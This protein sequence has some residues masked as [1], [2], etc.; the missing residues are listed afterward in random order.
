MRKIF[1]CSLVSLLFFCTACD[2][3]LDVTGDWKETGVVYGLINSSSPRQI[4]RINKAFLETE[5]PYMGANVIAQ[6]P[7]SL[8]FS[9]DME[10]VL[11]QYSFYENNANEIT[12]NN[13]E[14]TIPLTRANAT[15]VGLPPKDPGIFAT[16]PFYIYY[17]DTPI[18][19]NKAYKLSFTT[20]KGTEVSAITPIVGSFQVTKPVQPVS[21]G[22]LLVYEGA[23]KITWTKP[24]FAYLYDLIL[25]VSYDEVN[26]QDNSLVEHKVL[27]LVL[28]SNASSEEFEASGIG[29]LAYNFYWENFLQDLK[30]RLAPANGFYRQLKSIDIEVYAASEVVQKFYLIALANASN[31][32]QGAAI[33]PYTN[34]TNGIGILGSTNVAR[35]VYNEFNTLT[36]EDLSCNEIT[37]GLGFAPAPTSPGFPF[38]N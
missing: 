33:P 1:F 17:T 38:C 6:I 18:S 15:D 14:A 21:G 29:S 7:D 36:L 12:L 25:K 5:Q 2:N 19:E 31:I 32:N 11:Q 23:N 27:D 37:S 22:I 3:E 28:A 4:F 13:L 34:V 9:S 35:R 8:Y 20:D 16:D 10:V 30:N 26:L 24:D